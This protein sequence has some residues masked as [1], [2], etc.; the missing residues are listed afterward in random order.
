MA[1]SFP[2]LSRAVRI[3]A[4]LACACLIPLTQAAGLELKDGDRVVF[5]GD[6]FLEREGD[7]GHLEAALTRKFSDR[8]ITFR[9]LAWAGDTPTGKARASFDW[10]KPDSEWLKRV[11]EQVT[12]AKPT[13]V[14]LSYGMTAALEGG[15]E[16]ANRHRTE[17]ARLMDAVNEVGEG[18]VRFVLLSPLQQQG[19]RPDSD[20]TKALESIATVTKSLAEERQ[21]AYGDVLGLSRNLARLRMVLYDTPVL[22]NEQGYAMLAPR[23]VETLTGT[24]PEDD[25]ASPT[26]LAAIRKKNELFFHRWRPA[27]WTYLFGFRKHEQGRNSIEIPQFDPLI[28]EWETRIAKLRSAAKPPADVVAEVERLTGPA[29]RQPHRDPNYKEQPVP[30]FTVSDGL[31]VTLWAENPQLYKP[32]QMNWDDRG[33]LWVAS[34]RV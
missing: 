8:N 4:A 11:K 13:V 22:L 32:I 26:L 2:S 28:A 20:R 19:E 34:S 6:T 24:K 10:N 15:T 30:A 5:M 7:L 1:T 27:N 23:L 3:A 33:R 29:A 21:A 17:L 31:E 14:I 9:N 16:G 25:G 12:I 18:K